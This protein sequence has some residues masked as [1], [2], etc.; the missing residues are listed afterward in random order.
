[1]PL[2]LRSTV[3]KEVTWEQGFSNFSVQ[4][5]R[6]TYQA[7]RRGGIATLYNVAHQFSILYFTNSSISCDILMQD[8]NIVSYIKS[9]NL[10][11][12]SEI[13]QHLQQSN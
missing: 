1:M 12:D 9:W 6:N 4:D 8:S 2:F 5:S 3:D 10:E 13:V 11:E 7:H